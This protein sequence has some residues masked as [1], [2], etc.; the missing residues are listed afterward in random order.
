MMVYDYDLTNTPCDETH[1][2]VQANYQYEPNHNVPR[3][4]MYEDYKAACVRCHQQPVNSATFGKLIRHVFSGITTRRL[5]TRGESKYHYCGIRR[6]M[7]PPPPPASFSLQSPAAI[8]SSSSHDISGQP[9]PPSSG[10]NP[11]IITRSHAG[12]TTAAE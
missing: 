9:P 12:N 5:G 8:L 10:V 6:R 3:S 4:G 2:R 1:T 11:N 7:G